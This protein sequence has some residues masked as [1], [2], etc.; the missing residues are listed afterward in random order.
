MLKLTPFGAQYCDSNKNFIA[1]LLLHSSSIMRNSAAVLSVT[2]FLDN[3]EMMQG[4]TLFEFPRIRLFRHP[5][6][7]G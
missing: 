5:C 6:G 7:V 1:A 4:M 2:C 3:L